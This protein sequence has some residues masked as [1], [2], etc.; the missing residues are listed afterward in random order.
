MCILL[1]CLSAALA[2]C[3]IVTD[4][5]KALCARLFAAHVV[6]GE[7][8][9]VLLG[10]VLAARACRRARCSLLSRAQRVLGDSCAAVSAPPF[11]AAEPVR[12][13]VPCFATNRPLISGPRAQTGPRVPPIT[14]DGVITVESRG[15]VIRRAHG[16]S[17]P[18]SSLLNLATT[19]PVW[20]TVAVFTHTCPASSEGLCWLDVGC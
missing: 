11:L 15:C 10:A 13:D 12:T 7:S 6:V 19:E 8:M 16:T 5:R 1:W 2:A 3:A 20:P 9:R 14:S 17:F 4:W 18:P